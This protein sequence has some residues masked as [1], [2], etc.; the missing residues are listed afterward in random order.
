M[1]PPPPPLDN[2]CNRFCNRK[3]KNCKNWAAL[4]F[5]PNDEV[6]RQSETVNR[7]TTRTR[8]RIETNCARDN[9]ARLPSSLS[10]SLS[11]SL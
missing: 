9:D 11:L 10:L 7:G 4:L 1:Y 3:R 8:T 2:K 6:G 5:S